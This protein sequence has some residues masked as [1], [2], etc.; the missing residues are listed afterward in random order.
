MIY[1]LLFGGACFIVGHHTVTNPAWYEDKK[2]KQYLCLLCGKK[3][4]W[5][6]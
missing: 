3:T 1:R 5:M 2:E 6:Y 4:S